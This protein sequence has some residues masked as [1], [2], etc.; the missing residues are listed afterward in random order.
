MSI[1][2]LDSDNIDDI[3]GIET[4]DPVSAPP[5]PTSSSD[6]DSKLMRRDEVTDE[7]TGVDASK[8][9]GEFEDLIA[10]SK[11][12]M[13]E[14]YYMLKTNSSDIAVFQMAN[15]LIKTTAGLI[16]QFSKVTEQEV[17]HQRKLELEEVKLQNKIRLQEFEFNL[18][19]TANVI[20]VVPSD[21]NQP[22]QGDQQSEPEQKRKPVPKTKKQASHT[23][24]LSLI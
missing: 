7:V 4:S 14:A 13:N 6:G 15:D 3:L 20:S 11:S 18:S 19:K 1:N 5:L 17:E 16:K 2:I 12:I 9:Y 24:I 22:E 23:D 21:P 10:L 8:T